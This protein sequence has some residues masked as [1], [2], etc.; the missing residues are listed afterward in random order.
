MDGEPE[1][2]AEIFLDLIVSDLHAEA[3]SHGVGLRHSS[4]RLRERTEF[5]LA[6]ADMADC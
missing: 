5:F 4:E 2:L 3:I 6:G 1:T